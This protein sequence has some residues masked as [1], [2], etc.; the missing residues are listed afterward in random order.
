ME[1]LREEMAEKAQAD[2][3]LAKDAWNDVRGRLEA[4][5]K[6]SQD[7]YK[8]DLAE[9]QRDRDSMAAASEAHVG[10]L[11]EALKSAHGEGE[12]DGAVDPV[13]DLSRQLA[14]SQAQ[15]LEQQRRRESAQAAASTAM[16]DIVK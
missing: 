15:V 1:Q 4:E 11:Q 7:R 2:L 12:S 9:L 8:A 3:Q 6:A 5:L 13:L 14:E 10:K 16:T